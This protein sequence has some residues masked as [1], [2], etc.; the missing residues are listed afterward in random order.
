MNASMQ[1]SDHIHVNKSQKNQIGYCLA[2]TFFLREQKMIL[3]L[4][5]V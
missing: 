2:I 1:A 5:L 3:M 4:Q